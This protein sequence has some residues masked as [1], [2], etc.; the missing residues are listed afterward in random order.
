MQGLNHNLGR[1]TNSYQYL[2]KQYPNL[3]RLLDGA[4]SKMDPIRAN[5]FWQGAEEKTQVPHG[6][7]GND[8]KTKIPRRSRDNQHKCN[9]MSVY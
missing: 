4:H 9:E 3:Y 8:D 6:Q 2:F 7:V 1:E 5:F